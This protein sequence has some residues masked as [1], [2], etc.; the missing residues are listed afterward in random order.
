MKLSQL[1]DKLVKYNLEISI[2]SRQVVDGQIFVALPLATSSHLGKKHSPES[3][4]ETA[5]GKGASYIVLD[6]DVYAVLEQNNKLAENVEYIAV[7]NVR[8]AL[9]VLAQNKYQTHN[10]PFSVVAITGTNGKTTCAFLLEHLYKACGKRVAV[11]GTVSYHWPGHYEEAP[12]TTPDCLFLHKSLAKIKEIGVDVV[13]MEVSSHA[14]DQDRVAGINVDAALFTNLT[15]DHLDYHES[16]EN[17]YLAK[18]RLFTS[19]PKPEKVMGIFANDPF[20]QRILDLCPQAVGYCLDNQDLGKTSTLKNNILKAKLL[21]NTPEGLEIS[22]QYK[23]DTWL[24]QTSLV[25]EHNAL[26]LLGVESLALQLGF[27]LEDLQHLQSFKGVP[28]RLERI[29]ASKG[30]K[31]EG[32]HF[33]VDYAHTPDALVHAQK[34]LREAGFKRIITVFGCGGDRDRTKRP[35]MGQAVATACDVVIVTSDNPRTEQAEQIIQ[36]IIP[37]LENAKEVHSIVNRREALKLAVEISQKGDA[38]LVAGKGHETYQIIGTEKFY[39]SDQEIIREF[40]SDAQ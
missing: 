39:F 40:L 29:S 4:I 13:I 24:L 11:L 30:S 16:M 1:C 33:F 28:G 36:D 38:I 9:G 3:Y 37:S 19:V 20:G 35:L 23:D 12:L 34:A 14:L 32:A 27:S 7:E 17:Y 2:D 10:L 18:L 26:N 15:Q 31:K 21:A 6:V 22:H 25:G 8:K 5:V